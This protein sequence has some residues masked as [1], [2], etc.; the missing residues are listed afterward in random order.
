MCVYSWPFFVNG[1]AFVRI[2]KVPLM[3]IHVIVLTGALLGLMRAE[4]ARVCKH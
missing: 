1:G 2:G 3:G 4:R